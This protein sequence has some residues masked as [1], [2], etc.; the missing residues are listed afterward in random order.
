MIASLRPLSAIFLAGM[1]AAC[2]S[3]PNNGLGE[4]P[5]T[6]KASIEQM[7]QQ[8]AESKPEQAALLRLSAADQAYRQNDV[9]GSARILEQIDL[10]S[11][12]PAQ[13]MFASTLNAELAMAR[14][15]PKSALKALRHP[16]LERLSELPVEQQIRTQ[17]VRA[18]ALEADGQALAAARERVFIAPL[19]SGQ[20]AQDNHE[21]IW[22][23]VANLP[24]QTSAGG[25]ADLAG[26]LAL[27]RVTKGAATLEQ[28][29]DA[30]D[31]WVAQNPQHPAAMQLPEALVKLRELASQPLTRI[32]LLLPQEGQLASVARA[33]RDGFLA[34]H[35]E[36]Q[37]AGQNPR[38]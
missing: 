29:Q 16:S 3:S 9:A 15:Q 25:D 32:A 26:W 31:Q 2:A 35:Y 24:E 30:I 5:R 37:Q 11:L 17:L 14:K 8:A 21:K 28:Q 36:A 33:L 6:P 7:L 10:A 13:Q 1:L 22:E 34:A 19:L 18:R 20:Q 38:T 23:L 27:A 4:L 12:Q